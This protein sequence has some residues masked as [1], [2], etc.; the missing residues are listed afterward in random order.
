MEEKE[1]V[2]REDV[3]SFL[4]TQPPE[5][6]VEYEVNIANL[7]G[8]ID[9]SVAHLESIL[10]DDTLE[11]HNDTDALTIR[12]GAFR[13]LATYHRRNMNVT[14][15]E[16]LHDTYEH[17]FAERP[18]YDHVHAV[19]LRVRGRPEDIHRAISLQESLLEEV[20]G[21]AGLY[22]A[23][24]NTITQAIEDGIIADDEHEEYL[25]QARRAADQ[26]I[27]LWRGYG[28]YHVTKGR[29]LALQG[30]YKEARRQIEQG[31]DIED[32]GKD[33]YAIRIGQFQ[34]YLLRIDFLE[35]ETKLQNRIERAESKLADFEAETQNVADRFRT[36]M[37]QFLGFFTAIIAAIIVTIQ[38]ATNYPPTAAGHLIII[39]F[40]GLA[41]SF[42]GLSYLIP[43][44]GAQRRGLSITTLGLLLVLLG[45]VPLYL[46]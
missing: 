35:Y 7:V 36:T 22:Q 25:T 1:T 8:R 9:R 18:M 41:T 31:I 28:K 20:T 38:I 4:A 21:N 44:E 26:A 3:L 5:E 45:L 6:S 19:L 27:S 15:L 13:G 17:L 2:T 34:Q 32:P 16:N 24:A 10:A 42:G 33:D 30:E 23:Y 29:I 40:G 37:L 11:E 46:L 12:F 39:V 43:S 14:A